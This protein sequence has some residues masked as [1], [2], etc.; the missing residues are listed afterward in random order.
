[1]LE[2]FKDTY[3]YKFVIYN[4]VITA[5]KTK[6]RKSYLGFFW[7]VLSPLIFYTA[8]GMAFVYK[9]N[10]DSKSF[11]VHLFA[12]SI[13]FNFISSIISIAPNLFIDNENYIKKIYVPKTVFIL[14]LVFFEAI[15][16]I[17]ILGAVFLLGLLTGSIT[18]SYHFIFF[19]YAIFVSM[20]FSTG[21][22]CILACLGVYF[23]DIGHIV[24]VFL[25]SLYFMTPIIWYLQEA[26]AFMQTFTKFNPFYYYIEIFRVP[27]L[28]N[29]FPDM[30]YSLVAFLMAI[31]SFIVGL[32][33]LD[34]LKDKVFFKL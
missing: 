24:P 17:C 12:G 25:Q 11:V 33:T 16:S 23:R 32:W 21:L 30:K 18:I 26:P 5:L 4:F 15:N 3:K 1:M 28:D 9:F 14:S 27:F 31:V 13:A 20:L 10:V 22:S 6:Y 7:T 19:F 2:L 8:L 29:S 34:K